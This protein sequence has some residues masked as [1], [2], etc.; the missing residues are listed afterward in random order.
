[1]FR[2]ILFSTA[3]TAV[4]MAAPT[5][6]QADDVI[7]SYKL[8]E[9]VVGFGVR[10]T[11][12]KCPGPDGE[13]LQ[14][15]VTTAIKP[16]AS[17]GDTV[18]INASGSLFV[19]RSVKLENHPNGTI[20][21]FNGT[22]TSQGG[23]ILS[24]AIGLAS[25]VASA[26]VGIGVDGDVKALNNPPPQPP[27][28]KLTCKPSVAGAIEQLE[29]AKANLASLE[30][31]ISPDG[32]P[33]HLEKKISAAKATISSTQSFLT[34]KAE[35]QFWRPHT[36][37]SGWSETIAAGDLSKWFQGDVDK[38][39]ALLRDEF[40]ATFVDGLM[41]F[42]IKADF[43]K[44]PPSQ[45]QRAIDTLPYRALVYRG[46][47]TKAELSIMPDKPSLM[48]PGIF[49]LAPFELVQ[50]Y[51]SAEAEKSVVIPQL[52]KREE[53]PFDGSGIFGSK[54]VSAT[55][56]ED[57]SLLTIGYTNT[58]GADALAG[59]VTT[60]ESSASELR[61]ARLN[62]IKRK[63]DVLTQEELLEKELKDEAPSDSSDSSDAS[64]GAG[65]GPGDA[66]S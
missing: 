54:A 12:E 48:P 9:V 32:V 13:G 29:V 24:A 43:K 25:F 37:G 15:G 10:H 65:D 20:K 47:G 2:K 7:L 64:D 40:K 59:V 66:T 52:G 33:E 3:A 39:N 36:D 44:D 21:S 16:V 61:D 57:G 45:E 28:P 34:V 62:A 11:I 42:N 22:S 60:I 53:V 49:E 56:A 31:Q 14:I 18:S 5:Q 17:A 58:G 51:R 46:V 19:D 23:D 27:Q 50:K 26:G 41:S 63:V 4:T 1:M 38:I 35:P 6:A 8:P 30:A 55:F